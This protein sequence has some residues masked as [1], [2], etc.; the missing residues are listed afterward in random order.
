M[1]STDG[2]AVGTGLE[3]AAAD[4]N[5]FVGALPAVLEEKG[6][7]KGFAGAA[8]LPPRVAPNSD[9]PILGCGFSS[10]SILGFSAFVC[11]LLLAPFAMRT[12]RKPRILPSFL[13]HVF[14]RQVQ[15]YSLRSCPGKCWGRSP[16]SWRRR[17]N[18]PLHTLHF[19]IV[20]EGGV[21]SSSHVYIPLISLGK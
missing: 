13:R 21:F 7:E 16:S 11:V 6:F 12:P 15:I 1:T 17:L 19:A 10:D 4:E 2:G 20:P 14:L 18:K 8:V 9:A 5:G 3:L